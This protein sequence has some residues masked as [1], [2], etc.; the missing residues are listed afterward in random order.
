MRYLLND[1]EID[2]KLGYVIKLGV[3]H[4]VRAKTLQVLAYLIEHDQEV[5]TKQSLL[6]TIWHDVVVQEQV[7][8]QSIKEI[9]DLLGAEV[10]KTYPRQG[11]CWVADTT[12]LTRLNSLFLFKQSR[13]VKYL[14]WVS[15]V[16]SII[17]ICILAW[18]YQLLD[19]ANLSVAF[20]PVENAMPDNQHQWVPLQGMDY[21][22]QA[23]SKQSSLTVIDSDHLLYGFE[24][25]SQ[26]STL[27]LSEGEIVPL[28]QKVGA[29]LIVQTRLTGFPQDFQLHYTLFFPHGVERG[30]EL[31]SS[32]TGAY[33]KLVERIATRY[34]EFQPN[35]RVNYHSDFSN[36]AFVTGVEHYL[37]QDYASAI[38]L[39]MTALNIEPELLAARRYLAASYAN[40]N[41]LGSAFSLLQQ[42]IIEA[43]K[44]SDNREALRAYLMVGYLKINWPV[45]SDREQELLSAE[46]HINQAQQL[47]R[48]VV[49]KLFIAYSYEELGKIKRLQ[50]R[51]SEA[52]RLL[53]LALEYH[54]EFHGSYGQ[55]AALIELAKVAA[56]QKEED[57][58]QRY[59]AHALNIAETNDAPANQIWVLLAKAELARR[60]H[61]EL[62]AK[63]W[64]RQAMEVA[65]HNDNPHLITR[66]NAWFE[67]KPVYTVN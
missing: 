7:L 64:A 26:S 47:A 4:S 55:T 59:L 16:F 66:V 50:G 19:K 35:R 11:Y 30:V 38:P 40:T 17:F 1:I 60:Q 2:L 23:L 54:Q 20:L 44:V 42:N 58:S 32:V 6:D 22:T 13:V 25:L 10:I 41:E 39:L 43:E 15:V 51:Y 45:S 57:E 37:K 24:R 8:V 3:K 34:G 18:R 67:H 52:S 28:R 27:M 65:E 5:V 48:K 49:D 21:L 36:E 46:Q 62:L 56:E 31:A 12:P 9:R 61:N 63:R 33:D 53:N 29:E 14:S